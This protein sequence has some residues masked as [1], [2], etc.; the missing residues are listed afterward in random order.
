MIAQRTHP[1]MSNKQI[2][3]KVESG[4]DVCSVEGEVGLGR[5]HG[6]ERGVND[7]IVIYYEMHTLIIARN[8]TCVTS[9]THPDVFTC[10][11]IQY[12][13]D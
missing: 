2:I 9:N 13:K 4:W 12:E 10:C 6:V 1:P 7:T 5:R 8:H 3:S 11:I